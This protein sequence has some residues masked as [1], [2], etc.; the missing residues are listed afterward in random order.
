[1][2]RLRSERPVEADRERPLPAA[3]ALAL[4]LGLALA[5]A[6]GLLLARACL[7]FVPGGCGLGQL[8][9]RQLPRSQ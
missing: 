3:F 9:F 6:F 8:A 2:P 5:L 4:A 1:M 7:P